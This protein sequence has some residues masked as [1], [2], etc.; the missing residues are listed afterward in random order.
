MKPIDREASRFRVVVTGVAV[1]V[2]GLF[3]LEVFPT[4]G[5]AQD[6]L[7]G[8][9]RIFEDSFLDSLTGTWELTGKMGSYDLLQA[10]TAEWVLN[11]HFLRIQYLETAEEPVGTVRDEGV[12]YIGYNNV[13]HHYVMHLLDVWGGRYSET[14]GYGK[15]KSDTIRFVFDYPDGPFHLLLTK[16]PDGRTWEIILLQRDADGAWSTFAEKRL[17]R[18]M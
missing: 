17:R 7:D 3:L 5:V 11:H 9:H 8:P 16:S 4:T 15:R 1:A 14:L 18:V 2:T 6:E 12:A 10:V 13:N